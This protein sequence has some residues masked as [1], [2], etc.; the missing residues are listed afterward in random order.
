MSSDL[1]PAN[2]TSAERALSD[3]TARIADVPVPLRD[4]WN[5]DTCPLELLPWL[6]WAFSVDDWDTNWTEAQ[7]RAAVKASY[8]VHRYKGTIG[9]VKDAL[10]A[11]GLGVQVQEWFNMLP[12]GAPYTYRLLLEVNQYGVSLDDLA[13][14][15]DVVENAKNLRSHMTDLALTVK[16]VSE[17]Y[18]GAASLSGNEIDYTNAAGELILDG[19][20]ILDGSEELDGVKNIFWWKPRPGDLLLDGSWV[21]NASEKLD[22]INDN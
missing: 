16:A 6:A 8:S 17:V 14:I 1:L 3:A 2:S 13:K 5:P 7:Q 21:L 11:L 12:A 22:G 18:V 10:N 9:S 19:S 15:Q 4:L 20:W